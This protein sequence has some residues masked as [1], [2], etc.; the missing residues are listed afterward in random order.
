MSEEINYDRRRFLGSVAA[1][2]TICL[3]KRRRPSPKLSSTLI[4]IDRVRATRTPTQVP[5]AHS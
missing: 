2:V 1:S 5:R 3:K 4:G